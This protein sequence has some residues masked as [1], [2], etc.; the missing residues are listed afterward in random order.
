MLRLVAAVGAALVLIC[1]PAAAR[2]PFGPFGPAN[3]YTAANGAATM[4]GDAESSDASPDPGPGSGAEQVLTST[5]AAACPTVLQGSDAMP[6][7]LC[8]SIV[9]R[10][11][12]VY[13]LDPATGA[14]LA[15][16][17]LA[18]GNL[19][20]G[21][22]AYMD[23][24]NQ[25]V[26][27]DAA[28]DL[29]RIGHA[30][31]AGRWS[32]EI[33]SS[34][35]TAK[36][37]DARCASLC[38]G[39]VGLAPD[40][41]GRVWFATADGV[42]GYVNPSTGAV[43][44]IVLGH[45]EQVANSISTAPQGVAIDTDHALYVLDTARKGAPHK[46]WR[47][48]YRRGPARKPGQLSWGTGSTPTFFGSKNGTRYLT[49]TDN[50]SP[51][52]NLLVFD[53]EPNHGRLATKSHLVCRT[54]VLTP[55]PSGT[56]NA[57]VGSGHS[58]FIASTYGYPYPALPAGAPPSVPATAPFTGGVTRVDVNASGHGCH[59]VWRD[60]VRSAAVPRLDVPDQILYTTQRTDPLDG[61]GTSDLDVY[62]SV[63]INAAT[64]AVLHSTTLGA[65]YLSDTLQLAPTIVPGRVMYQ[66]TISGIDR[67]S[68]APAP[69]VRLPSVP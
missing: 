20:G 43:R 3:P 69:P 44:T 60:A 14:P 45:G 36:A 68:P 11:P 30:F 47:Y 12:T 49:I 59:T 5:L 53:S 7:A 19:F 50:A 66:G 51:D 48:A 38:G 35:S 4:H 18:A 65:G 23:R 32:L 63:A 46:V 15:S 58:V 62:S 24:R 61:T 13:L 52:E 17:K 22:Y 42:A 2:N 40:W 39:V 28:G 21:V 10:N 6:V 55:G 26:L 34:I 37:I 25:I 31:A 56:E 16:L 9:G 57:P 41:R 27:F 29:L 1:A 67:I 64:G 54:P 33:S 8:T